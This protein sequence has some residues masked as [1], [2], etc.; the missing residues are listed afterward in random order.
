MNYTETEMKKTYFLSRH[1]CAKNQVDAELIVGALSDKGWQLVDDAAD[2]A[3]IVINSC[4]FIES[5]K[6]ESLDAVFQARNENPSAKIILAGCLAE[7]YAEVFANELPEVDAFFG[8]GDISKITEV[9][10]SLFSSSDSKPKQQNE[11]TK[12]WRYPQSGVSCGGRPTRFNYKNSVYI[13]ITEGCS[14]HCSFCAIP[15]IRGNVRSR[16]IADIVSEI[17][18]LVREGVFEFNLIGQD[19]AAFSTDGKAPAFNRADEKN[20]EPSGLSKLLKAISLISGNFTI[21]LLYIHPDHFPLDILPVMISDSRFL[22]YFDLPFQSGDEAILKAMNRCGNAN[23]YSQLIASI[24]NA[25]VQTA[26]KRACIRTTFLTG[27]PGETDTAFQTTVAFLKTIRP[28]WSG[29]FDFSPEENT[30]AVLLSDEVPNEIAV[31]RKK[32][33]QNAQVLITGELLK[34]FVGE[35]LDMLVEE[36]IENPNDENFFVLGRAWFQAPEV[37]GCIVVPMHDKQLVQTISE[38][39]LISVKIKIVRNLDLEA[40]FISKI[41]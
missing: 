31:L 32:I 26:Y 23:V 38:G 11:Q 30:K 24:Q 22:P 13:K 34:N 37:D 36:I 8:N 29:A 15:L 10:A 7:R 16:S 33:L 9:F 5:A 17:E 14:N 1:G 35:K 27:F 20:S 41:R 39:S 25:F 19:L 2:A 21:R 12:V 4:G 6:K 18:S 40:E 28:L 3:V